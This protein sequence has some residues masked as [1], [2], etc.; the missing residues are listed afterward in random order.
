[1][2]DSQEIIER[3]IYKALLDVAVKLKYSIDPNKYLPVNAANSKRFNEDRDKLS[4]YIPIFSSGDN[5]STDKKTTPRIVVNP[6]GF[7]PGDIGMPK[8]LIV[9]NPNSRRFTAMEAPYETINQYIDIHLVSNN[10]DDNRLLHQLCFWALPQRGYVKPYV[11]DKFLFSGNIFLE[12]VNFY[13]Q[14]NLQFG[15]IEKVY[16]FE[17][18]DCLIGIQDTGEELAPL[19]DASAFFEEKDLT[20]EVKS[21]NNK[22][23]A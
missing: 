2:I 19:V 17:V 3:S 1:M 22:E 11:S 23:D 12:L 15:L 4:K 18:Q 16:E 21:K 6:K 9:E 5:L 13:D 8:P 14:P 7:Y 20:I 10:A